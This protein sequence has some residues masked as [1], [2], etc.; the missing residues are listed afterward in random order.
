MARLVALVPPPRMHLTRYHGVFAPHSKLRAA[1]TPAGRGT[2]KKPPA[3]EGTDKPATPRHMA[4]SWAR[5]LKRVF[6]I[7]IEPS[8]RWGRGRRHNSPVCFEFEGWGACRW[9]V[10][11]RAG[12]GRV[13]ARG[14]RSGWGGEGRIPPVQEGQLRPAGGFRQPRLP[15]LAWRRQSR[16]HHKARSPM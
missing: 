6:G 7:D 5:R 8:C 4:M 11:Q 1:V 10:K 12:S 3:E 14:F 9:S 16:A 13:G 2:G 15:A